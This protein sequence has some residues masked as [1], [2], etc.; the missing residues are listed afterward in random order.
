MKIRVTRY[1][2]LLIVSC[3]FALCSFMSVLNGF[4]LSD[5]FSCHNKHLRED[6]LLMADCM[7]EDAP[8]SSAFAWVGFVAVLLTIISVSIAVTVLLFNKYKNGMAIGY[9]VSASA[10]A[11]AAAIFLY[12]ALLLYQVHSLNSFEVFL[13]NVG[14]TFAILILPAL[15]IGALVVAITY[16]NL[17]YRSRTSADKDSAM[18]LNTKMSRQEHQRLLGKVSIKGKKIGRK[19]SRKDFRKL[20]LVTIIFLSFSGIAAHLYAYNRDCSMKQADDRYGYGKYTLCE[21]RERGLYMM[22]IYDNRANVYLWVAI[23]SGII[24]LV[25]TA[26]TS[27]YFLL[28]RNLTIDLQK[29]SNTVALMCFILFL[30]HWL[31][32]QIVWV[33]ASE[34]SIDLA[35][36]ITAVGA[37]ALFVFGFMAI[38]IA[39]IYKL[40][41]SL[42]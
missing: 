35:T 18:T 1:R 41:S 39:G 9:A 37:V 21:P 6:T 34:R 10:L 11:A 30:L 29:I 12:K 22:E 27:A 2:T 36:Y 24:S 42:H 7:I 32:Y 5:Y 17:F 33:H 20:I 19:I 8:V 31:A 16:S 38:I 14:F 15:S 3:V 25:C 28:R 23:V 26:C 13:D 40:N 4:W